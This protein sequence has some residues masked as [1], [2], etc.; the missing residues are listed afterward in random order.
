M[1]AK[2][3]AKKKEIYHREHG[4]LP[5]VSSTLT[6]E[7]RLCALCGSSSCIFQ[8]TKHGRE[9]NANRYLMQPNVG[10]FLILLL[11]PTVL[12]DQ[13]HETAGAEIGGFKH[14][15]VAGDA[16]EDLFVLVADGQHGDSSV[17]ELFE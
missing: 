12:A 1:S 6:R 4:D 7:A 14:V 11:G 9:A 3:N 13:F 15:A 5:G 10:R 17:F 8:A 2:E 16:D